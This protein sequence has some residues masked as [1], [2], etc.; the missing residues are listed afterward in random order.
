VR[1]KASS[2][3]AS[4]PYPPRDRSDPGSALEALL[5]NHPVPSVNM[6]WSANGSPASKATRIR[7][8][9]VTGMPRHQAALIAASQILQRSDI[10]LVVKI[11]LL[12]RFG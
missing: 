4:T 2:P 10:G 9:R 1:I 12:T 7:M 3:L 5:G 8:I 11:D 6:V